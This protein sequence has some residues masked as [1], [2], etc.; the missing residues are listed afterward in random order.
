MTFFDHFC[1]WELFCWR[2]ISSTMAPKKN[3][4]VPFI[5]IEDTIQ[6]W[7]QV[8][9]IG[10]DLIESIPKLKEAEHDLKQ[11]ADRCQ[12]YVTK[13]DLIKIIIW[14]HTVG[15][16]RIY[17]L[18]H[19]HSND[20]SI[21]QYHSRI[22]LSLISTIRI[23]EFVVN[24]DDDN[25]YVRISPI[26]QK[27]MLEAI[28]EL[29]MIQ[30]VGPATASAILS[31]VRPD[32]FCYLYDHVIDCFE[33]PRN[34]TLSNYIQVNERC[35]QIARQ[36]GGGSWTSSRVAKMIWTAVRFLK[37]TGESFDTKRALKKDTSDSFHQRQRSEIC[38]N[39]SDI[40]ENDND[41]NLKYNIKSDGDDNVCNSRNLDDKNNEIDV[42]NRSNSKRQRIES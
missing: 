16:N 5:I 14:K 20:E 41:M 6:I 21:V 15:Q 39:D 4:R 37:M 18:K 24:D 36:L 7:E 28:T 25:D 23:E 30:G 33:L 22:A 1:F 3:Q 32:L 11:I 31:F 42:V 35:I 40:E 2:S 27:N 10:K 9:E 13:S 34:Y 29:R 8:E 12:Q 17:N 38:S 26:G 19:I